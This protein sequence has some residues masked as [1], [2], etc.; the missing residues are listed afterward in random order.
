MSV[1]REVLDKS[2]ESGQLLKNDCAKLQARNDFLELKLKK[3]EEYFEH[4]NRRIDILITTAEGE[5][6]LKEI[7]EEGFYTL[8]ARRDADAR[9]IAE[10]EHQNEELRKKVDSLTRQ[11]VLSHD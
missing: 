9:R 8:V 11:Q 6:K 7:T 2:L 4:L 10:L 5:R 1:P 3:D